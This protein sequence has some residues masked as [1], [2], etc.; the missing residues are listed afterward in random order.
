MKLAH[1]DN[2]TDLARNLI[3]FENRGTG[4]LHFSTDIAWPLFRPHDA[5]E[6]WR[7]KHLK[8]YLLPIFRWKLDI[9]ENVK[10]ML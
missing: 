5:L 1:I 3:R 10:L 8:Q 2:T 9:A 7:G 4:Y 6:S